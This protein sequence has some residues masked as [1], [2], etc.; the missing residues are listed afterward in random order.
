MNFK[1]CESL[2]RKYEELD[3]LYSKGWVV[4]KAAPHVTG[5]KKIPLVSTKTVQRQLKPLTLFKSEKV[6]VD[7]SFLNKECRVNPN[8]YTY[9]GVPVQDL[10]ELGIEV[11][12]PI[13]SKIPAATRA[14]LARKD[15]WVDISVKQV[16][17][18][19]AEIIKPKRVW[20]PGAH[21]G[22]KP[23]L[24]HVT[25]KLVNGSVVESTFA[26]AVKI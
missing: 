9:K 6:E 1:K 13:C 24:V 7:R 2:Q 10:K 18:P 8:G 25:R 15:C 17:K 19:V 16:T 26:R 23:T 3:P 12:M 5:F 11:T 4:R 22:K 20:H 21:S 14:K